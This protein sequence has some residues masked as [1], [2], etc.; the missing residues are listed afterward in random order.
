MKNKNKSVSVKIK[1][2][3]NATSYL[4]D[5]AGNVKIAKNNISSS[6]VPNSGEM[7]HCSGS[8]LSIML[9]GVV[10]EQLAEM[11]QKE[12]KL[13]NDLQD[14]IENNINSIKKF[15]AEKAY[16][17]FKKSAKN[18]FEGKKTGK[19]YSKTEIAKRYAALVGA[20]GAKRL[21]NI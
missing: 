5:A 1:Q 9:M 3:E 17:D 19:K 20:V 2:M 12:V 7:N 18:K 13:I 15:E 16:D 11:A 10:K 8:F 6:K 21:K 14:D 4:G